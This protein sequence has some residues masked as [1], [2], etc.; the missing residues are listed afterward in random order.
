MNF[1]IATWYD[2]WNGTGADNL[3]QGKVPLGYASRYNLAFGVFA[4]TG[5][6]YTLDLNAQFAA[7]N[8]GQIKTQAPSALIYAGVGDTGLVA[9][10][11]DN[12]DNAN[13]STANIVA[14]LQQQGLNGISI[15]SEGDGMSSVVELVTQLSP[16][17]KAAGL[18][19]A[20]SVPWPAGGPV[21]LYGD[22]AVAAF[23]QYVD[24]AELQDYS[25]SGTPQDAQVWI[26]AGVRADI[27]MGGVATENGNVQTSL[28]DTAA[29][30]SYAL[31][32]GLRGMFSWRLDND[33]GQDGQEEDVDPTFTGA[34]TIYDTV[35]AQRGAADPLR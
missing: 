14:Y 16:S 18:G 2:T 1:E 28:E 21:A 31:Q 27:L 3:A 19:I 17:F 24:A 13:R 15:D 33:H 35:Y 34:K 25:S 32:N 7:Q 8:L 22:G 5:N 10:V 20:V 6:G 11:A 26:Q 12:R 9:T 23:N 29:W 30:T 4:E